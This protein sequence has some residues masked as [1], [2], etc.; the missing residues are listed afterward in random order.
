MF[1]VGLATT[2]KVLLG[3]YDSN[4]QYVC[5]PVYFKNFCGRARLIMCYIVAESNNMMN[6]ILWWCVYIGL[7]VLLIIK[8]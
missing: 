6:F 8:Y 7:H 5:T 1:F 3:L 4:A 2:S